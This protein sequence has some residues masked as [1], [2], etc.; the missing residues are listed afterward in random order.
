MDKFKDKSK[1]LTLNPIDWFNFYGDFKEVFKYSKNHYYI[2]DTEVGSYKQKQE[3][4]YSLNGIFVDIKKEDDHFDI[5]KGATYTKFMLL[6]KVRFKNNYSVAMNYVLFSLMNI[7]IPFIRVGV[8]YFKKIVKPTRYG[9]QATLLKHWKK[10]EIKQD[11]DNGFIN[12]VYKYDDFTIEPNNIDY[13]PI[14]NNFYNLYSQFQHEVHPEIVRENE[15]ETSIDLVKHIFGNKYQIGLKYLKILFEFPKQILP[16]IVLVSEERGTG[17]TTF[18]N[19]MDMIFGENCV[20]ISPDDVSRGFNSIYATKNI[21]LIDEAVAEKQATVEKLK[22][23]ATAKTISVSQKFVSEYSIPFYGKVI[24][25]TNKE[26]DFMKID[27]EEIRFFVLKVPVIKKLNTRI[28]DDLF[29]EIPKFLKYLTQLP[30]I[31]FSKSRMVF[32]PEEIESDALETV[33]EESRSGLFKELSLFIEDYF[34]NNSNIDEF[35]ATA[36]DIKNRF[37]GNNNQISAS[38]IRK[39]IKNEYKLTPQKIKRYNPFGESLKEAVG[40]PFCFKKIHFSEDVKNIFYEQII[41]F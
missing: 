21:I 12:R 3:V 10:D 2:S 15:I 35:D 14:I 4:L 1:D 23:I 41:D 28:E 20:A 5:P 22:S 33:K 19:W 17:K 9:G 36:I 6:T 32:T 16:I 25:C 31:D 8:D 7:E 37:F 18:L 34:N 40:T 27:N 24:L 38:Y 26:T 13:N 30:E 39:V 29:K 11:Y